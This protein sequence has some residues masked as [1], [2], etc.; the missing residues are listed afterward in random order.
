M[1]DSYDFKEADPRII[2][3][4][5]KENVFKFDLKSKKKIFSID[6]PPPTVSGKMHIGHAF[7][8]SQQDFIARYKRMKG[9]NIFYPFGTDD[10]GLPTERLVEKTKGIRARD[11][12]RE[13]FIKICINFLKEELP[14]FVQDWKNIGISSDF[15]IYYSTINEHCRRIS[16]WSFLD[17]HKKGR[18]YRKDAPAMW[19]PECQTG[20]SQ[21][22]CQD[23]ILKS[24]FNHLIFKT[25]DKNIKS[26][27][28]ATTRPELLPACVAVFYHPSDKRYKA[29][30]GRMAEVP[31]F[32]F[33][34]PIM[35]DERVSM[36]KGTGIVMCCTFGDQTDM[37]WQKAYNLPIKEAI[38]KD[39]RMAEI[40][41]KYKGMRIKGARAG[42]TED[43]KKQGVLVNEEDIEHAVNVHERCGTEIE[44]VKSKQWFVRY[45]DLKEKMLEWG[46]E[47]KWHPSHMKHRYDNWIKGLQWDW[48]ISRQ[49]YFGVPF[50]VWYCKKCK[51]AVLADEN[52][53]PVDPL[54][55]KPKKKCKCGSTEFEPE[56]DVLDTWFT[57]SMTPQLSVQLMPKN[58]QESLFPMSL[59]PQAHEIITFWLFN[60]VVKSN[61]HFGKN[62]FRDVIISGF[63]TLHGEK[64]AKSKG[65]VIEPQAVLE[66]YGADAMRF[67]AASSKMGEDMEY[68]ENEIVA[69]KKFVTKLFNAARFAFMSIEKDKNGKIKQPKKLDEIDRLFLSRLNGAIEN[70]T[71]AFECYEYSKAKS[72]ADYFF[73]HVFCDNYLEI[74]KRRT[75]SGTKEEKESAFYT[76]NSA[77]LAILK[78]MAPFTPFITEEIYQQHYKS[79][80]KEKSIHLAGWPEKFS[81]AEKKDDADKFSLLI[82]IISKVRQAKSEANKSIKAEIILTLEKSAKDK[83]KD[84]LQDLTSV[85]N[86]KDIKEGAFKVE[87]V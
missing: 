15:S 55:D 25:D 32:G 66:K 30:K 8:Y 74:V 70:S 4:W 77:L 18:V 2:K 68:R 5:E 29:L 31:L 9:F 87:F 49:R 36:D 62:P 35:E 56:N 46:N 33:K 52:Q 34:V 20:I 59:R 24:K 17:L 27:T 51:E 39:G 50:P 21:V 47:L 73:W 48:L 81:I 28:I 13:D 82:E 84:V 7:S 54:K 78:M 58:M 53:L 14:S 65:N 75:Y 60:T 12:S 44:F 76:L 64:M 80:E 19:C 85:I 72:E 26:I 45:L 67:W 6:T 69:G 3:F 79:Q 23:R 63:V 1:Q 71:N 16:Q 42:I 11:F 10:N 61:L 38:L 57:S 22:E 40:A 37:E 83:L 86:A 41:E 43:L